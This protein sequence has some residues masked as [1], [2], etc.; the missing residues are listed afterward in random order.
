MAQIP[1]SNYIASTSLEEYFVDENTGLPL[2]NGA[3]Y[4]YRD[5]A[6]TTPKLVYELTG[7]PSNVGGYSFAPLP[8]PVQLS[9][10]GTF[11]DNNGNNI[12]VYYYPYDTEGNLDLYYVVVADQFAT[13]EF[14]RSAWPPIATEVGAAAAA[15]V[16]EN[17]LSN[18]Q[19]VDILFSSNAT[20]S[21]T[22]PLPSA[23][24][25]NFNIAPD[26]V[27]TAVSNAAS[28]VTVTRTAIAG[29]PPLVTNPPYT[30]TITPAANI[31]AQ[32]LY[33][34]QRLANN[35]GIWSQT[36][37]A[38]TNGY[39]S[40]SIVLAAGSQAEITY[41]PSSGAAT[42]I[43]IADN[44]GP[45]SAVF[46]GTAQL[47]VS[48]SGDSPYAGYADIYIYLPN[49]SSTTLTSVQVVGL[50]SDQ[51]VV[52]Y[53]QEPVNRQ[54][55]HLYHYYQPKIFFKPIPSYLVGWDFPL[56][57]ANITGALSGALSCPAGGS[58]Y[59]W[60]QTIV[61]SEVAGSNI[62]YSRDATGA[63]K[64]RV[65][66]SNPSKIAVIQYLEDYKV[67]QILAN[68]LSVNVSASTSNPTGLTGTIS[69]WYTTGTGLPSAAI[70]TYQSIV[71]SLN[72]D[73][74]IATFNQPTPGGNNWIQN[75]RNLV[76][77]VQGAF[78]VTSTTSGVFSNS[79][80]SGWGAD[81][82]GVAPNTA[83]FFAIV[84]GFASIP[85]GQSVTINSISLV[86]GDIPTIPAPQ[87]QD[88]VTR[89]CQRYFWRTYSPG[90]QAGTTVWS[91]GWLWTKAA[92]YQ[93]SQ[94][95]PSIALTYPSTMRTAPAIIFYSPS[96]GVANTICGTLNNASP[97]VAQLPSV[98][99]SNWS[100]ATTFAG[101]TIVTNGYIGTQSAF[102]CITTQVTIASA[103]NYEG[104]AAYH[105]VVDARLGIV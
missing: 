13:M 102:Y 27:L 90:T 68:N 86:P 29:G 59:V 95:M 25:Y 97:V 61:W 89:E 88:E 57:P 103:Q 75:Q 74:S 22:Y 5:I 36:G 21:Q 105:L 52:P 53:V 37:T 94:Q 64:L 72:A 23:G 91:S 1:P 66:G 11:M 9:A 51:E 92:L 79:G 41:V 30:L 2:A 38:G 26:W 100:A 73:G 34:R 14:T 43:L 104:Y 47:P 85:A 12:A 49:G 32:G 18:S 99:I 20:A 101:P 76:G 54:I 62:N 69:L 84:V 48:T 87:T 16:Y 3:V 28:S 77:N 82:T 7:D 8:N 65:S 98:P 6:R 80:I 45:T 78:S 39:I 24:T 46:N 71:A 17:Q 50:A 67:A 56:N 70:G 58:Q 55:D 81:T 15:P 93:L 42:S 35:P 31:N 83:N 96:S 33:L 60:D 4:F 40:G 19:F 63:L 10:T 44:T